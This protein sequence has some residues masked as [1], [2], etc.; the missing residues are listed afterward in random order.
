[1][2]SH[3]SPL[4]DLSDPS[5][6]EEQMVGLTSR[7][8]ISLALQQ[9]SNHKST[10][11]IEANFPPKLLHP[12]LNPQNL[13]PKSGGQTPEFNPKRSKPG[14]QALDLTPDPAPKTGDSFW[15]SSDDEG[16]LESLLRPAEKSEAAKGETLLDEE[17]V[18]EY[19]ALPKRA[20]MFTG[21]W[22]LLKI[23]LPLVGVN[24]IYSSEGIVAMAFLGHLGQRELAG[25][26]LAISLG[27]ICG[28][29]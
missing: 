23:A 27:N 8:K 14:F 6:H 20:H 9:G 12:S 25:G 2:A 29:R 15:D 21:L 4:R 18:S 16:D 3:E 7:G 19:P 26:A 11:R 5:A 13:T 1:M 24:A 28:E 17:D 22:R 10:F